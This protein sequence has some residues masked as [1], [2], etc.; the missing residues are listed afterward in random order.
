MLLSFKITTIKC[1][2]KSVCQSDLLTFLA[3]SCFA[4][5]LDKMMNLTF[6]K[7]PIQK[8]AIFL[9]L[10]S[11]FT[12]E[13]WCIN[14]DRFHTQ[15]LWRTITP[16]MPCKRVTSWPASGHT[17][18]K[19]REKERKKEKKIYKEIWRQKW[20]VA[21]MTDQSAQHPVCWTNIL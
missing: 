16:R 10:G 1:R 8:T 9:C 14:D 18:E 21:K 5:L 4:Q 2:S 15:G 13:D 11:R 19:K 12:R 3:F 6:Q 7:Q 17:T 20:P